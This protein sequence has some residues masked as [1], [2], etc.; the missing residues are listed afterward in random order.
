MRP[1]C[2]GF[3]FDPSDPSTTVII[4]TLVGS[5]NLDVAPYRYLYIFR[6][7]IWKLHKRAMHTIYYTC[8]YIHPYRQTSQPICICLNEW[9]GCRFIGWSESRW[10]IVFLILEKQPRWQVDPT[11]YKVLTFFLNDRFIMT[12]RSSIL[13]SSPSSKYPTHFVRTSNQFF[14]YVKEKNDIHVQTS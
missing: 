10:G 9:S 1:N 11:T 5:G 6:Y 2:R 4:I 13:Q 8:A 12:V 7:C 14:F 3:F